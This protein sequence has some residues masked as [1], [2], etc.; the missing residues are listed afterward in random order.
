MAQTRGFYVD[1]VERTTTADRDA[2]WAVVEGIGGERGW[3]STDRLWAA[4]A[5]ANRLNLPPGRLRHR[6]H[7]DRLAAGERLDWW[8][9]EALEPPRRLRLRH[10]R[11]R[12]LR[13]PEVLSEERQVGLF[14]GLG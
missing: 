5:T 11:R 9:V 14:G 1:T 6:E 7:P 8:T 3:Y 10:R 13:H 4:R 2:V 12:Q